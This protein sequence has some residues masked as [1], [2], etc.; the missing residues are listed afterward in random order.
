MKEL[1]DINGVTHTKCSSC[2]EVKPIT[3]FYKNFKA[4]SGYRGDCKICVNKRSIMYAKTHPEYKKL[5]DKLYMERHGARIYSNK[6]E[7]C[8]KIRLEVLE[9]YG[10]KCVCCGETHKVFLTLDH[11]FGGGGA[12]R[13][14]LGARGVYNEVKKEGFPKDRYRILCMNCNFATRFGRVCPHQISAVIEPEVRNASLF[15]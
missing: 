10:G 5:K 7:E 8:R 4:K 9:A 13:Q 15:S 11:I 14:T 2:K 6:K 12:H 1:F 3:D